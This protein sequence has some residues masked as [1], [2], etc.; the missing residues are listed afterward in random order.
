MAPR[1][2]PPRKNPLRDRQ[3]IRAPP[4]FQPNAKS[5]KEQEKLPPCGNKE[6]KNAPIDEGICTGCGKII[7]ESNIVSEITFGESSSGAA[8]VQGAF[9]SHD[10]GAARGMGPAFRGGG[11]E[12]NRAATI[13]EGKL[14]IS[15]SDLNSHLMATRQT[16]NSCRWQC[17]QYQKHNYSG[18]GS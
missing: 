18:C 1:P 12:N 17:V 15:D 6:C 13:A 14:T 2:V 5:Q 7:S 10:Q 3:P 16:T 4:P 9:L 11:Q 8:V